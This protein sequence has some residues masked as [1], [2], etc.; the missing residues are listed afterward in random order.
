MKPY[1]SEPGVTIY[2]ADCRDV[3]PAVA[4]DTIITDPVWPNCEHVFPGIDARRL[5]SE[6]LTAAHDQVARVVVQLGFDSPPSRPG[7]RVLP[8]RYLSTRSDNARKWGIHRRN[9]GAAVLNLPHPS[10]RNLQHLR[11]LVK[12]FAGASVV[13]PF[14]GSGTTAV[15]CKA[16]AVPCTLI[17][18]EERYCEL[19]A[20]RIRQGTLIEEAS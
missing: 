19:A 4:A 9:G 18:L 8:G 20:N 10:M 7:R 14:A 17:E 2:N 13:D 1:Y 12:W 15:A 11:W 5:L 16:L 6:A 3:L